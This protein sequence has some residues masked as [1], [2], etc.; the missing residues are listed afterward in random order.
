MALSLSVLAAATHQQSPSDQDM[1]IEFFPALLSGLRSPKRGGFEL[2]T[3]V[4][5]KDVLFFFL[6]THHSMATVSFRLQS[7]MA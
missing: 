2:G 5:Q 6:S 1:F 3:H 4:G 7:K